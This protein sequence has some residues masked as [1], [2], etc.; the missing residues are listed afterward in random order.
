M[1]KIILIDDDKEEFTK[2]R[3]TIKENTPPKYSFENKDFDFEEYKLDNFASQN[4]IVDNLIALINS[5]DISMIIIDYKLLTDSQS[6]EGNKIF[7]DI[8]KIVP[9]FPIVILTERLDESLQGF[10]VDADKIYEKSKFFQ[11]ESTYSKEKVK[12]LFYNMDSYMSNLSELES[13]LTLLIGE[14]QNNKMTPEIINKIN[15]VE[16][17]LA[18]YIPLDHCKA[19]ELYSAE[20]LKEIISLL[21]EA[22]NLIKG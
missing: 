11:L 18:K 12:N 17:E 20:D 1:Y 19:E 16:I 22:N 5:K 6:F 21:S 7:A 3:M 14:M 8:C 2:I 4:G 15:N 9:K 13:Q 10:F